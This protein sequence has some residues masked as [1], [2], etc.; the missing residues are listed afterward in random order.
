M[1]SLQNVL[2]QWPPWPVSAISSLYEMSWLVQGAVPM[3]EEVWEQARIFRGVPACGESKELTPDINA[4]EAGLDHV[5][6]LEKGCFVGQE[7]LAKV[8]N[9]QGAIGIPHIR[10]LCNQLP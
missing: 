3:G 5:V 2:L 1:G 8:S 6:S 7:T 4:L 9:K 10:A